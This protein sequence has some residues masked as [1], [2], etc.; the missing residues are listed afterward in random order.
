MMCFNPNSVR[1][2]KLPKYS[3][4]VRPYCLVQYSLHSPSHERC[5]FSDEDLGK[6]RSVE[7]NRESQPV[8]CETTHY[9]PHVI[10][11]N[12]LQNNGIKVGTKMGEQISVEIP[13]STRLEIL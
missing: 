5:M 2:L 4:L 11:M 9:P 1:F 8:G 13:I 3:N 7:T 12:R 10:R 6:R